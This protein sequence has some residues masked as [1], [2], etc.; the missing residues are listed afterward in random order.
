[1]VKVVSVTS[2]NHKAAFMWYKK[3]NTCMWTDRSNTLKKYNTIR[4]VPKGLSFV[5]T[6]GKSIPIST[7]FHCLVRALQ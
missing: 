6:E 5:E 3:F 4:T 7:Y 1:M 2:K